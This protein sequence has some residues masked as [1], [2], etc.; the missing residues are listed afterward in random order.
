MTPTRA[1]AMAIPLALLAL[2]C[3]PH[4]Q[5]QIIADPKAPGNQRPTVLVA[6]N[7]VPLVNIQTP[8]SAG[9][10]RNTYS[11]F[12]INSTG[13]I[14]NNSRTQVQTQL[15]G[16]VQ[17]NPWLASGSA[18]VILNEVNSSNPSQLKG[19]AEVAGQ[20]AQVVIANPAG[21]TCDGCGFINASRA[22]LTTGIPMLQQGP[23]ESYRVHGG[24]IKFEG[25]GMDARGA[26]ITEV[27]AHAIKVNAGIW[28]NY[29][30]MV[31]G[32]GH[33]SV[34]PISGEYTVT[35]LQPSDL[36]RP[37]FAIDAG[38]LGGMYAGHIKL[39]G[40]ESG[41]GVRNPGPEF[42]E[43]GDVEISAD[44]QIVSRSRTRIASTGGIRN[45]GIITAGG[46][47]SLEAAGSIDNSGTI[48]AQQGLDIGAQTIHN[49]E[50]ALIF[51]GGDLAIGGSLDAG[52][53]AT[54]S[55]G[56]IN[57][58]G[59]TIDATGQLTIRAAQ[60]NNTNT[61]LQTSM[62]ALP[63]QT[64]VEYQG[65]GSP[66]RYP[67]GTPGVST[68]YEE[69][70][71]LRTPEGIYESWSK[72]SYVRN[73]SQ[74]K[75][76]S[77]Q[78]GQ[79]LAGGGMHLDI[80]RLTNDNSRIIAGGAISG[81]I[82]TLDN[83][84]TAG[85]RISTD[86]GIIT[87][88]WRDFRRGIDTTGRG[89]VGYNP[90]ASVQGIALS[91]AAYRQHAQNAT[92]DS[93]GSSTRER[94]ADIPALLAGSAS[95]GLFGLARGPAP[96]LI[97]TNPQ[98]ASYRQWLGS[99]YLQN[100]L[101]I[102]PATTQKRLGD[103]F[104]EQRLVREQ[105]AQLTGRRYLPGHNDDQAQFQTLMNNAVTVAQGMQ[106]V[107]GI[108]LSAAQVAQLTSDI[109]WL[110]EQDVRLPDG[111]TAKALVPQLYVRVRDGDLQAG[112]ALIAGDSVTLNV[113]SELTNSGTIAGRQVLALTADNV[114]NLGGRM[115]GQDVRIAAANDID[116]I[117]GSISAASSLTMQA[118]R[119]INVTTT[120]STRKNEQ[121]SRS[122]LDRVAGLYVS[123]KGGTLNMAAGRD[124]KL[125]A[126]AIVN[127]G[128]VDTAAGSTSNSSST[129]SST[130]SSTTIT[131]GNDIRL[132]T[133]IESQ[134]N[135]ITWD[136]SNR[137]SDS[138]RTE[139]GTA[140]QVQGDL[141]LQ[142]GNN[143]DARAASIAS[144]GAVIA[145]AA[146][147]IRLVAGQ[148]SRSV[149][150]AHQH[151]SRS[152]MFSS[153]TVTTRDTFDDTTSQAT[154]VSGNSVTLRA[155]NNIQ[156]TASNVAS[157]QG[158]QLAAGRHID[159]AAATDTR[160]QTQTR[161]EK[162]SGIFSS[163]GTGLTIGTQRQDLS[164]QATSTTAAASTVGSTQG[165]VTLAA[166]QA[167]RQTGSDVIAL[168]GDVNIAAR[169]V[170]IT[171]ARES[172]RSSV[173]H[174]FQQ[175]G[176]TVAISNPVISAVQTARQM[177]S[178]ANDTDDAR[179]K[180]MAGAN[181][182]AS[183]HS[184][185][186]AIKAGQGSSI[187]GTEGQL[188]T[189]KANADGSAQTRDANAAD[190]VGGIDIAISLGSSK[191]QTRS[192]AT[193][194]SARGATVVAGGDVNI[195]ANANANAGPN[196]S[197]GLQ[198]GTLLV[199]GSALTAGGSARLQADQQ[200][201]LLAAQNTSDQ[202][203]TNKASSASIGVSFGT[204]G[205]LAIA[206]ASAARGN[207][208]STGTRWTNARVDAGKQ[209]TLN[210][211]GDA[212]LKGAVV[213]APRVTAN[214]G[215]NLR[216]ESL[217]DSSRYD[218]KQKGIGGGIAIGAG[219]V[220]GNLNASKS[221]I[222]SDYASV[223]QQSGIRA[224]DE[225]FIVDVAKDTTLAGGAIT[226]TQSAVD[227]QR[228]RFTTGG[229]LSTSD[230]QN[231]ASYSAKSASANFGTG[232]DP[233]GK[234]APAGTGAGV[235]RD[236]ASDSSTTQAAISGI[237]G[238]TAA[239]TSDS[240]TGIK[241]IFDADK[242][243]REINAQVQITQTFGTN[244]SRAVANYADGERTTL[245][246]RAK[247][248]STEQD[249]LAIE[250]E[251]KDLDM[252][253]RAMNVLIGAVTGLGG[254]A[255]TKEALQAAAQ[256][257]RELM[258]VDSKKFAGITDGTTSISN[259]SGESVGVNGDGLKIGGTRVDLDI[260]CGHA[261]ERCKT[262]KAGANGTKL[263]EL[264]Y[265]GQVQ[266]DSIAAKMSLA[267]FLATP[268]GKKAY[269]TTGGIQGWKGT[270]FGTPYPAGGWL[271]KLIES[272][273][274]THDMMGGTLTGLYD[275]QG[276][277]TRQM[278]GPLRSAYDTWATI[279][280]APST[281]FALADILPPQVWNAIAIMLK[282]A[283]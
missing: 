67:E 241:Q 160:T 75:V 86:S 179:A 79:I 37:Y 45:S 225:G 161:Q 233:N 232:F 135:Q 272:F 10:S 224:G 124:V 276:N 60:L 126:A 68:F 239:R 238:N 94:L 265:R 175:S 127:A 262:Q 80:G 119:D 176:I 23:L 271:D 178:A 98:F 194:E 82:G 204:S 143:I 222:N 261:N 55:A 30:R 280:I 159:I 64:I 242:V 273:S 18:R 129:S 29:L 53:R 31:A 51:S 220:N 118:G 89:V 1:L 251:I 213:T 212:T 275:E 28:A 192:T 255:V 236:S 90:P 147:D 49:R 227:A 61:R 3:A 123:G 78:P 17:G 171:E 174:S 69:S 209:V 250:K 244:A 83:I 134:S 93:A 24:T 234:L 34:D 268:E 218:S 166:G 11:Q 81:D 216:I 217:Q 2:L 33:V 165:D 266:F 150:E 188:N 100:A 214:I 105:V 210:T 133:V 113:N 4:T 72:Y 181:V 56:T 228:N 132:G 282:A 92:A 180:V 172:S 138:S 248:A 226:S 186:A 76:D 54:G 128:P 269:G 154:T 15:G 130:N 36:E 116:N 197:G 278:P 253:Q 85:Q 274:G 203:S 122:Y 111:S 70:E 256:E 8:S 7:N 245:R 231:Q 77:S 264:D 91:I 38:E 101:S 20:K 32:A 88:N 215:G 5:A 121:G 95:G 137:R 283:K 117:G 207:A 140:I 189:G 187:K 43:A 46:N 144:D 99:D 170:A 270:F 47:A 177:A 58:A 155:G 57:N 185:L 52:G 39:L 141:R 112:G 279:A 219:K 201:D 167:Y 243:Q 84:E 21:I 281:P 199:Q 205:L 191:S 42:I 59:A 40:S 168:T 6:P 267:E 106:L 120:T 157:D 44:G 73:I 208:D 162:K 107:P 139:T 149:D 9:V 14:L 152:G 183:A 252:Q 230:V 103:G 71:H 249:K 125:T 25:S 153:K 26:S 156:V 247:A 235:G 196:A 41:L 35:P 254:A 211:G 240:E 131:A 48:A 108:A 16:W 50:H 182:A 110:V 151:T 97:E 136:A 12:D 202:H 142:A 13:V 96:T 146:N 263:L 102:D 257:M 173:E 66:T 258:I 193:S 223:T 200:I 158:T 164:S 198:P 184:A 22:T 65:A 104:V 277:I 19:P 169:Q 115:A 63:A 229:M 221:D 237:A 109:V 62:V 114:R 145:T 87:N 206:S 259:V 246:E 27:L 148:S 195:S 163:G 190:K 260:L 74:T